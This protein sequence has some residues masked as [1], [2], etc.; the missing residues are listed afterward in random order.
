MI[1]TLR[2]RF[3]LGGPLTH[4]DGVAPDLGSVFTL[5]GPDDPGPAHLEVTTAEQ[6]NERLEADCHRPLSDLQQ[7]LHALAAHLPSIIDDVNHAEQTIVGHVR[8]WREGAQ[9]I[10]VPDHKTP[11]E[12]VPYIKEQV[13]QFLA[14][15]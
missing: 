11:L 9:R 15:I 1:A 14:Q 4:R 12:A 7:S 6:D 5:P 8:A 2:K 3:T 10:D 13:R